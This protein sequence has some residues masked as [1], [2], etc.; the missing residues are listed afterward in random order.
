MY[1]MVE[2]FPLFLSKAIHMNDNEFGTKE[3]K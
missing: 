3:E 1:V 2:F